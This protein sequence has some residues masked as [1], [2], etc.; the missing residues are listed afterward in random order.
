MLRH[1]VLDDV[2]FVDLDANVVKFHSSDLV[3]KL[4]AMASNH[5]IQKLVSN[6]KR[7]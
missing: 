2:V 4:D 6:P 5:D 7:T 1:R 3:P